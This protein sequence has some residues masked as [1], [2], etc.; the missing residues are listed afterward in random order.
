MNE[1][2]LSRYLKVKALAE[3]GEGGEK[4]AARKILSRLEGQYP[5]IGEAAAAYARQDSAPGRE[6]VP[7]G[8]RRRWPFRAPGNWEEIFRYAAGV[9][10]TVQEV[11]DDVTDAYYG[12]SLAEEDVEF[13]GGTRKENVF[14]R[15]KMSFATVEEA[16]SLNVIQKESFRQTLHSKLDTYLDSLLQE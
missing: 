11:M 3:G 16:R 8:G 9:Y 14:I 7:S 12:Q 4:D 5:G 15:L 2:T 13:S 10:E 1:K 6:P